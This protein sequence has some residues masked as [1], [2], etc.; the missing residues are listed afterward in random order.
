M[1]LAWHKHLPFLFSDVQ[2]VSLV[3]ISFNL[4]AANRSHVEAR[5]AD[6]YHSFQRRAAKLELSG[7]LLRSFQ[8]AKD[9]PRREEET[10]A[11]PDVL[12]YLGEHVRAED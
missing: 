3:R 4:N 11:D 6:K 1:L 7:N 10:G 8:K 12:R 2:V 9:D 5:M